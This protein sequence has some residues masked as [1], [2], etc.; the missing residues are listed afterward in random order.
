VNE[1]QYKDEEVNIVKADNNVAKYSS[2]EIQL[3]HDTY[4][5]GTTKEEFELYLYTAN[6]FQ[7]DPL[8]KQ[9][10]CVKFANQNAQIY[11]GR[12]GFL[13]IAHRSGQFN[14]IKSGMKDERTAYAEVYRKDMDNPF[15]VEVDMAEYST[16]QAL[17]KSK[18]RTMLI[19]VAESQALR[20]A[21]SI[22]GIYDETEMGQWELQAQGIKFEPGVPQALPQPQQQQSNEFDWPKIDLN[23]VPKWGYGDKRETP[24]IVKRLFA[25]AKK[26]EIPTEEFQSICKNLTGKEHSYLWT[27]G[28]I[29]E[30]EEVL[31]RIND[32]NT[33]NVE[34]IIEKPDENIQEIEPEVIENFEE[35]LDFLE[36]KFDTHAVGEGKAKADE[37]LAK[38]KGK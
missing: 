21:F 38:L 16:G 23:S 7:L 4:A 13:Q 18:P 22:S 3:I 33:K 34:E 14:G 29:K 12:D 20:R 25:I 17:W 37:I 30:I 15:Y 27:Y 10:W 5:K 1:R 35:T 31:N 11:A 24:K 26:Y 32:E 2:S 28:N 19:K 36:E 6:K 9:I 8:L